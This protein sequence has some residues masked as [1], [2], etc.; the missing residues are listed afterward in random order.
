MSLLLSGA[1]EEKL[2]LSTMNIIYSPIVYQIPTA[3][4]L[5]DF[6]RAHYLLS[7][8]AIVYCSKKKKKEKKTC[9]NPHLFVPPHTLLIDLCS[10][11][12]LKEPKRSNDFSFSGCCFGL[13]RQ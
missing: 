6:S 13:S 7:A 12:H 11:I 3:H 5:H 2:H 9:L 8:P 4:C 1:T 10:M